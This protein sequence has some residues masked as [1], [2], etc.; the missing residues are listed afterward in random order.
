VQKRSQKPE[1]IVK[2]RALLD[3]DTGLAHIELRSFPGNTHPVCL[4]LLP[5][6]LRNDKISPELL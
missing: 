2:R 6:P 4:R 3:P 5:T 1:Q